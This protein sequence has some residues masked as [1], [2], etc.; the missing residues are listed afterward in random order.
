M[1][2]RA[3]LKINACLLD[4]YAALIIRDIHLVRG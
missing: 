3:G 4:F 2:G 1:A